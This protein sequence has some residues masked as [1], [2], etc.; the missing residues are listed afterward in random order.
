[1]EQKYSILIIEGHSSM[2]ML[3]CQYLQPH[4]NSHAVMNS[5]EAISWLMEGNFPHLILL[6]TDDSRDEASHFLN[7]L[8]LSGFFEHIPVVVL[9]ANGSDTLSKLQKAEIILNKPFDPLQLLKT[10]RK[11]ISNS[12]FA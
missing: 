5:Y 9:D 11:Q 2:R 1:M 6:S 7:H 12:Q 4:F 10:V 8:R 3:L